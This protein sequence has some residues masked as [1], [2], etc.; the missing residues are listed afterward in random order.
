MQSIKNKVE[1]FSKTHPGCRN[2]LQN[3]IEKKE[4]QYKK[5]KDYYDKDKIF[6]RAKEMCE[7]DVVSIKNLFFLVLNTNLS[8]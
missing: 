6:H 1:E 5:V 2:F 3:F 4:Q 7:Y 8:C